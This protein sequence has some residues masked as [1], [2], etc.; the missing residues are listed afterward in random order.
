[1]FSTSE[2]Y[3][4]RIVGVYHSFQDGGSILLIRKQKGYNLIN[5]G[6]GFLV[7]ELS[8]SLVL[9]SQMI[10]FALYLVFPLSQQGQSQIIVMY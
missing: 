9:S 3:M 10:V 4:C 2:G 1:M 7:P 6:V 5:N 8:K